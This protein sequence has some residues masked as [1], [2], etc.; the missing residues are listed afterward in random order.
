MM[1]VRC[2]P[3][4]PLSGRGR[5]TEPPPHLRSS[6]FLASSLTIMPP[7]P[8]Y[9]ALTE[10]VVKGDNGAKTV[11]LSAAF[12]R[13]QLAAHRTSVKEGEVCPPLFV[14]VQ[15]PQG[16]G[17]RIDTFW[18]GGPER[19]QLTV[20]IPRPVTPPPSSPGVSLAPV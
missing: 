14:G 9:K 11:E 7:K 4:S 2:G 3:G 1:A 12:I 19:G 13:A 18:F 17:K 6:P 8:E 10:A 15:G 16:C 20:L 5:W